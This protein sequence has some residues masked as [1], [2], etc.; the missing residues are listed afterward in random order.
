VVRSLAGRRFFP[1]WAVVHHRGRTT[2][3]ELSLPV[4]VLA[5]PDG[6]VIALPW[7]PG[8]NW[9]RNV[10]AAGGCTLRWR[11]TDVPV[12]GPELL[13]PPAARP[14]YPAAM[15]AFVQRVFSPSAFLLLHRADA[16][17]SPTSPTAP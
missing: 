3:R 5:T 13:D 2:G 14:Y 11:G 1:Q 12:T 9:V 8:T 6:F 16:A 7:G 15:W 4:A 17:T 10:Q